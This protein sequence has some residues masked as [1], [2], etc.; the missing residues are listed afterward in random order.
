MSKVIRFKIS[1]QDSKPLIWRRFQV[2]D[3]YRF[4]QFHQVIQIVMGWENSH[5]HK[6]EC[7]GTVYEMMMPQLM[8]A[9]EE[10][11]D[12]TKYDLRNAK[13]KK[14][15]KIK[16]LYD[17]GDSWKHTILVEDIVDGDLKVPICLKGENACPLEDSGGI[18]GYMEKVRVMNDPNNPEREFWDDVIL[19]RYNYKRFD[20]EKLNKEL[21]KF[22]LWINKNP[23]ATS[24]PWHQI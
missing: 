21:Q 20:L 10:G 24:T 2:S 23:K 6:F 16:Y 1:L 13:L 18:W 11:E 3:R 17:Y 19:E 9:Y 7:K 15:N 8:D 12:E 22:G 4:D 14:G 5:L